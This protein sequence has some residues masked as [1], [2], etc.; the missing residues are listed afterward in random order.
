M[1]LWSR[2]ETLDVCV[3]PRARA[4]C[5]NYGECASGRFLNQS[6]I[7]KPI[8]DSGIPTKS[9]KVQSNGNACFKFK[10]VK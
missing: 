3:V 7:S 8:R 6:E 10:K 1:G 2:R 5:V 4:L 9:K